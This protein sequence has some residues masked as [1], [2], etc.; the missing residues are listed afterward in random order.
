MNRKS[1]H[2]AMLHLLRAEVGQ[3]LP[4]VARRSRQLITQK[5]PFMGRPVGSADVPLK[6]AKRRQAGKGHHLPSTLIRLCAR[7][8]NTFDAPRT[9]GQE[10]LSIWSNWQLLLESLPELVTQV[11]V[12]RRAVLRG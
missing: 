8:R 7:L 4:V 11:W 3:L 10:D 6:A 9:G 12:E 5:L 1:S 2:P